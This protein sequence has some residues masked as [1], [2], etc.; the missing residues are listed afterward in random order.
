[1]PQQENTPQ[2]EGNEEEYTPQIQE[3]E[4]EI[5]EETIPPET[6]EELD[7]EVVTPSGKYRKAYDLLQKDMV[8]SKLNAKKQ[9]FIEL[10]A[11]IDSEL[12]YLEKQKGINLNETRDYFLRQAM[13]K[14]EASRAIEGR[15]LEMLRTQIQKYTG[16]QE[17]TQKTGGKSMTNKIKDRL[18]YQQ[19][20]QRR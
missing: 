1:M 20:N 17:M 4:E 3:D 16:K 6:R 9:Q 10:S 11:S 15:T 14:V 13:V 18:P 19:Q 12:N 8:L 2:T 7:Y 5:Y